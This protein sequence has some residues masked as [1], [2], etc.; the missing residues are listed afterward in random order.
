MNINEIRGTFVGRARIPAQGTAGTSNVWSVLRAREA[1][2]VTGVYWIPDA[3]VTGD[4]S[5]NFTL[6][7]RNEGSDG[8]GTTAVT[9]TKTYATGTDSVAQV[10]EALTVSGTAAD[11]AV[12]AGDVLSLVRATTGSGLASPAGQLEIHYQLA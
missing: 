1:A 5:D 9:A 10:A 7:V 3:A 8:T 12:A 6:A 2:V 4:N 11:V